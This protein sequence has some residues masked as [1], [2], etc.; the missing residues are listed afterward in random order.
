MSNGTFLAINSVSFMA[1]LGT[2][3]VLGHPGVALSLATPAFWLWI[4]RVD[5]VSVIR[6]PR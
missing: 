3:T 4:L 2:L 6:Q 5:V 1:L